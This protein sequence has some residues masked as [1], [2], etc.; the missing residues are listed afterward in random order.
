MCDGGIDPHDILQILGE[1]ELQRYL[2]NEIQEVYRLQ[3]VKINDKHIGVIIRQ[4]MKKI[5]IVGVGDT[6]FIYGQQVD[7]H[8]FNEENRK[9][10]REGGQPAVAQPLLLG[11][12][13]ASLNIDSFISAASFQETTRVLTNSSIAGSSDRLSG[14]KENV[15]IGHLIPAGTGMR[16]YREVTL[17]DENME[18]LDDKIQRILEQR[19]QEELERELAAQEYDDA[20]DDVDAVGAVGAAPAMADPAP[21]PGPGAQTEVGSE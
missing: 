5:E 4:M 9:V 18:N 3:G 12:T 6:N 2:V 21:P 14:L 17:F 1:N 7:R 19:R 11:I 10:I 15:I 16:E 20:Y 13:R 8:T